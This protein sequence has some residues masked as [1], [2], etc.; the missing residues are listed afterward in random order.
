M[1]Q[2]KPLNKN[3]RVL[4]EILNKHLQEQQGVK[5]APKETNGASN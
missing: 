2:N 4:I 5:K 1:K 3:E